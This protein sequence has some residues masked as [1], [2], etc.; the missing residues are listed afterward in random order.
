MRKRHLHSLISQNLRQRPVVSDWRLPCSQWVLLVV[1]QR[2]REES[3][4]PMCSE[5]S[6]NSRDTSK[7]ILQS[8][9]SRFESWRPSQPLSSLWAVTAF[10]K[11]SRHF[12]RLARDQSVSA[13]GKSV[14]SGRFRN[15][16]GRVSG[17]EFLISGF[18]C[19]RLGSTALRPALLAKH[20][21][22]CEA[23]PDRTR[24]GVSEAGCLD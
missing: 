5:I 9:I 3:L 18:C 22:V 6:G 10:T 7:G 17:R 4:V 19:L 20:R 8:S 24:C 2:T 16:C 21:R 15:F 1:H 14:C 13:A 23:V 12:G 11:I